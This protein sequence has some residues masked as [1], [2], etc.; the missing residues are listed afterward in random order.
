MKCPLCGF[1]FNETSNTCKGCPLAK[2]CGLVRCPNCGYEMPP[3]PKT[4]NAL[5]NMWGW[6]YGKIKE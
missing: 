3:E 4:L 1:E 2:S 5:K 6:V